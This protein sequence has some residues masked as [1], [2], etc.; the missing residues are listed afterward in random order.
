M[1]GVLVTGAAGFLGSAVCRAALAGGA[2]VLGLVRPGELVAPI[3]G[4]EYCELDWAGTAAIAGVLAEAAPGRIVHCAGATPRAQ[5]SMSDLYDANVRLVWQLLD[6]V[7]AVVPHAGVVVPSTAAVYGPAPATPAAEDEPLNPVT[8]YAWSKVLA[9][10]TVRAFATA[11]G[12]RACVARP[13]N[14]LGDGE[15]AGSVVSD[16]VSQLREDP[17][18]PVVRLR[19]IVSVRD[20]IYV[21]D[22]VD[23]LLVLAERGAPGEV[24]NVCTGTGVSIAELVRTILDVWG[25]RAAIEPTMPDATGT[26]SIGSATK[27][28]AL[29]WGPRASLRT[30]VERASR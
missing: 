7:K 17:D 1:S 15:P 27:L 9:E 22:A 12:V 25:S 4:V 23:A 13:F 2:P 29:G 11:D 24:Y 21:G 10:E 8:H 14:V 3:E 18:T 6:A 16:V 28:R 19:E 20:Y 26:V 5:M 30:S